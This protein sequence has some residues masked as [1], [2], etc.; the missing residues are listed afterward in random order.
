MTSRV[1]PGAQARPSHPQ[2]ITDE[3]LIDHLVQDVP[4]D[5]V[6]LARVRE[7]VLARYRDEFAR[8]P[9]RPGPRQDDP[10]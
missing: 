1:A 8:Q 3:A 6:R 7:R 9:T 10:S 5:P 4:V 2:D